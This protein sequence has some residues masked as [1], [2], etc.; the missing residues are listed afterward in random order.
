MGRTPNNSI[1]LHSM[2]TVCDPRHRTDGPAGKMFSCIQIRTPHGPRP[3][4]PRG[5][6][7][8]ARLRRLCGRCQCHASRCRRR[9]RLHG[10]AVRT[11]G[12][13]LSGLQLHYR[14]R[15]NGRAR[16]RHYHPLRLSSLLPNTD[17]I[18]HVHEEPCSTGGGAHYRFDPDAGEPPPNEIHIDFTSDDEGTG[19]MTAE[20]ANQVDESAH[21]VI[22]HTTAGVSLLC[23]DMQ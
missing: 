9:G 18:S 13:G 16:P 19:F 20:N 12:D 5:R 1:S 15:T 14:H 17:Y 10:G 4:P 6:G 3:Q 2:V 8:H 21:S 11:L 23:A 22:V 7:A